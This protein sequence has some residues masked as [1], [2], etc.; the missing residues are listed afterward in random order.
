MMDLKLTKELIRTLNLIHGYGGS[1]QG[2]DYSNNNPLAF[3]DKFNSRDIIIN[4]K[5]ERTS[6]YDLVFDELGRARSAGMLREIHTGEPSVNCH[7]AQIF[8]SDWAGD[9]V[10][11]NSES[12]YILLLYEDIY[13]YSPK[14]DL[15]IVKRNFDVIFKIDF[16]TGRITTSTVSPEDKLT[17]D[18][19]YFMDIMTRNITGELQ[20][21]DREED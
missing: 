4:G 20:R 19:Y 17:R 2:I 12:Q 18:M 11:Y 10:K 15:T 13:K 1:F 16:V 6:Y 21:T 14:C 9:A 5:G 7:V 3:E 8:H